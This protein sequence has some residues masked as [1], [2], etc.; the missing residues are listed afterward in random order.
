ME[1]FE[2][3]LYVPGSIHGPTLWVFSSTPCLLGD[4]HHRCVYLMDDRGR[5]L[6]PDLRLADNSVC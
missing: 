6:R 2:G 3:D 4:H 5:R 1:A